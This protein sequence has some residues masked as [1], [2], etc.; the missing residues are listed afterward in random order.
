MK[1]ATIDGASHYFATLNPA[2]T[3]TTIDRLLR[4][5]GPVEQV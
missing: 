3:A 5:Q 4:S 1:A 2:E